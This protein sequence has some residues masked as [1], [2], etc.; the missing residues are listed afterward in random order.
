[1]P[2]P[3][4][5]MPGELNT[6]WPASLRQITTRLKLAVPVLLFPEGTS[7]DGSEVLK[8]HSSLFE[9]AV[10]AAAQV[11][12]ACVRYTIDDGTAERELCWFDETP[13]LPHLWKAL[14]VRGFTAQ[15]RFFASHEYVDRRQAARETHDRVVSMRERVD[16]RPGHEAIPSVPPAD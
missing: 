13:F 10:T 14:G 3:M 9:P 7:T 8:F 1:M 11:T 12:A 2:N 5:K 4:P 15:V 16:L 6:S